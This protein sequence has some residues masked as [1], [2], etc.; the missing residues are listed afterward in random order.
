MNIG[1]QLAGHSFSPSSHQNTCQKHLMEGMVWLEC[2]VCGKL[3]VV[4]GASVRLPD[5][6]KRR[7]SSKQRRKEE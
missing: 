4:Q 1:V 5:C 7:N 3:G 2:N 6:V